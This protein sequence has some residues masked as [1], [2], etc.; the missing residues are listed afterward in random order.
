MLGPVGCEKTWQVA[1]QNLYRNCERTLQVYTNRNCVLLI[2]S[3]TAI[4]MGLRSVYLCE[5]VLR[6]SDRVTSK[7]A[8]A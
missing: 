8:A 6:G 3:L 5:W 2:F 4:L 7:R 1:V